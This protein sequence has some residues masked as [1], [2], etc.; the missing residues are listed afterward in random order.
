MTVELTNLQA[1]IIRE[2]LSCLLHDRYLMPK[3]ID[4]F[5]A[6]AVEIADASAAVESARKED[7]AHA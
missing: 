4:G 6:K 2:A 7:R 3:D 1:D 5:L